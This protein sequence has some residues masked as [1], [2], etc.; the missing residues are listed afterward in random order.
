MIGE[1]EIEEDDL[2]TSS[3]SSLQSSSSSSDD[4]DWFDD[5]IINRIMENN[6]AVGGG[7]AEY[8]GPIHNKDGTL[9]KRTRLD[10]SRSAKRNQGADARNPWEVC[11]WL[12]LVTEATT[13]DPQSTNGKLFRRM[14]RV[15]LPIFSEI[16]IMCR[17]TNEFEYAAICIGGQHSAPL[18]LK[19]LMVLRVLATGMKF[20]DVSL[21]TQ[22]MSE[23]QC[24]AFFK[25]FM[26]IFR[27]HF[28]HVYIKELEGDELA[29]SMRVYAMLGLPG[30]VGSIDATFIPWD[31]VPT[32]EHNIHC[33]DKGIGLLF[34]VIVTHNKE[35]L[36]VSGPYPATINDKI[37]V[38]YN[39]F[40]DDLKTRKIYNNVSYKVRT[41]PN[42]GDF[43]E[44][45]SCYVIADGL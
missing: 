11:D 40:L 24:C 29:T 18:E 43:I 21:C 28:E 19:V 14:F 8:D 41:G 25:K 45:S 12:K 26:R 16:V 27:L 1:Y 32:L 35:V 7:P 13:S 34:N 39:E 20:F 3:S 15:P 33:G 38:K 42:V 10:Y 37:S 2:S 36:S 22:Y 17:S 30:C 5:L 6:D 23:V 44:L 9:R 4:D 31:R